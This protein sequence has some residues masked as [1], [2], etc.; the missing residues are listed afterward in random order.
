MKA[1]IFGI[2]ALGAQLEKKD[3]LVKLNNIFQM[4]APP[5]MEKTF[6][7][8]FQILHNSFQAKLA[9]KWRIVKF[10]EWK[11]HLFFYI[12]HKKTEV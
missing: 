2:C 10:E 9:L 12:N 6:P 7:F 1:L 8:S 11:N 5:F 4:E 3:T